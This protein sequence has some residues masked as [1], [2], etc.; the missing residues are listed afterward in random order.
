M[1][2]RSTGRLTRSN[3]SEIGV[4]SEQNLQAQ[5]PMSGSNPFT[6]DFLRAGADDRL[7]PQGQLS[8]VSGHTDDP[9]KFM[10]VPQLLERA[11]ARNGSG[12]AAIF[13]EQKV[14]LSWYDLK[15]RS[16]E[17]AAGLLALG[18]GR[19]DRVGIWSPNRVEW[20]Y[21]QFG[22]ARIGAILVN[23]NPAYQAS[24]LEYALSRVQC[25][26]LVTA[27]GHRSTDYLAILR[28]LAPEIDVASLGPL[29][30]AR[31]PHMNHIVVLEDSAAPARCILFS[32]LRRLAGPGH[33]NRLKQIA[34][35]LD[36]DDA[37]NI[38]YTS[39]TTG[40]PKGTTLSHFNIV[41]N[42]RYSAKSMALGPAD[43]LCIPVPLYHCFGM[44]LGVLA[45]AAAGATMVF[46]GEA[47]DAG[48]T[49]AAID[50]HKCTALHGVPTMFIGMLGHP[51]FDK[52]DLSSLRTGIMAGAPCP[53]EIMRRV[54]EHM[55]MREVTIAYGMT[56]TSPVSFQSRIDDPVERRVTTVGRVHPHVE[57]KLI[58]GSGNIVAVGSVGELC[59]RGYSVMRGYW[60]EE[61]LTSETID[62]AGWLHSGDLAVIDREGFCNIVGRTKDMLIRGGENVYPR[63]V[64]EYLIRHPKVQAAQVFGIPDQRLGEE[65]CAFVILKAG[66][67]ATPEELRTFCQGSIS[68][69]KIPRYV[70]FVAEFPMTAT[71]KPQKFVMRDQM[72]REFA[73][74]MRNDSGDPGAADVFSGARS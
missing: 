60:D 25:K 29:R 10:T 32:D 13:D 30:P 67:T 71:G 15:S 26:V 34:A 54:V 17:I 62:R 12:D 73:S 40:L 55:N 8:Y 22:T 58:D 7:R 56:E 36:P 69:F 43:R 24:E 21:L 3:S 74:P 49:L 51:D 19:G 72:M 18:V 45:S 59:T 4:T 52:Y 41:N 6:S 37:I 47:F 57:V 23:V 63:E 31:L 2:R 35:A 65:V 38:Q 20:L 68:H 61:A 14:R 39:G 50:R 11:C 27:R 46:P 16:D 5:Q 28:S 48:A 9:L 42:A 70:R 53:I 44:V 64:E 66:Q 33:R 1:K